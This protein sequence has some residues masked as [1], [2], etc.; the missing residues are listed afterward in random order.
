MKATETLGRAYAYTCMRTHVRVLET[1]KDKFSA[2][3]AWFGTNPTLFGSS[4]KTLLFY[5]KKP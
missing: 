2:F 1:M 4:S 3:K 5:Y